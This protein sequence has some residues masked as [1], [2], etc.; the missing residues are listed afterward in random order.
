MTGSLPALHSVS[1]KTTNPEHA[2][3]AL[4][5]L[6]RLMAKNSPYHNA[7]V[8]ESAQIALKNCIKS[9]KKSQLM[10]KGSTKA[11]TKQEQ[12]AQHGK[13]FQ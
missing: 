9:L 10:N 11:S 13:E 3:T 4:M 12:M 8:P 1:E 7:K 6:N 2:L 5:G